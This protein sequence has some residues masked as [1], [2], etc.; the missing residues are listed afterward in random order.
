MKTAK[1]H[2]ADLIGEVYVKSHEA[3]YSA[4]GSFCWA[5]HLKESHK[6]ELQG[7]FTAATLRSL[8]DWLDNPKGD[9]PKLT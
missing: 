7:E 1:Q 6:L 2:N 9:M 5:R 8:A 4:L 3:R